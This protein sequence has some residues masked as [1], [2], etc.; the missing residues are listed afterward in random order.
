MSQTSG[1]GDAFNPSI[2]YPRLLH[3]GVSYGD[4]ARVTAA[5]SDWRTWSAQLSR[6]AEN[7]AAMAIRAGNEGSHVSAAHFWRLASVY[8][9]YSQI[10]LSVSEAKLELRRRSAE[11][12]FK[13]STL[14]PTTINKL[15]MD[16]E[17]MVLPGYWMGPDHQA[18]LVV[19]VGGLDSAKEVEL[20]SFAQ[21]FLARGLQC[22]IFDGPGQGE[23]FGKSPLRLC[24]ESV[25]GRVVDQLLHSH[26]PAALGV[27][28]VSL[29]GYLAARGA[30][31]DGRIQSCVSLGGFYDTNILL[32][33]PAFGKEVLA[34]SLKP[35]ATF[36]E[37]TLDG[38]S[39][40]D[41]CPRMT[42]PLFIVHGSRDHL[43]SDEQV[44]KFAAWGRG[45][46]HIWCMEGAEHVCTDRFNEC[47]PV[48]G[49]WMASQLTSN[50]RHAGVAS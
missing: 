42:R 6:I 40:A 9:H 32:K 12:F 25:L 27:F 19:L 4:L 49:D 7:Y 28:G 26:R 47:L 10:R 15:D 34:Y 39:V 41:P 20:Y 17:D 29:G 50:V 46:A 16:L 23:L 3:F 22:Y 8:F 24:F 48:I 21:T 45:A 18:P 14:S 30:G 33:L 43:V 13:F 5:S 36:P 38:S 2:L 11:A 31:A 35:D 1:H 44:D 37:Q